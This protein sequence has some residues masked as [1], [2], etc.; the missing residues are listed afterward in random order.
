MCTKNTYGVTVTYV[1]LKKVQTNA[2]GLLATEVTVL[3]RTDDSIGVVR[4]AASVKPRIVAEKGFLH[5]S[6]SDSRQVVLILTWRDAAAAL[7]AHAVN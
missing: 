3:Q 2:L 1:E 7:S 6:G 4:Q 5:R